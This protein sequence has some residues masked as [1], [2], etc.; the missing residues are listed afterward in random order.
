MF[1]AMVQLKAHGEYDQIYQKVQAYLAQHFTRL[2]HVDLYYDAAG[3][4]CSEAQQRQIVVDI[5]MLGFGDAIGLLFVNDQIELDQVSASAQS[6]L[7]TM[8]GYQE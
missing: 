8:Y 1:G 2:P 7:K 6:E 4:I 5:H 3:T